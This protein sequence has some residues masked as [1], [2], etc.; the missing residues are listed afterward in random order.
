MHLCSQERLKSKIQSF[1]LECPGSHFSMPLCV[2]SSSGMFWGMPIE[3]F[4]ADII[5][6]NFLQILLHSQGNMKSLSYLIHRFI[7][8]WSVFYLMERLPSLSKKVFHPRKKS[9]A[10]KANC[11]SP[12]KALLGFQ[13]WCWKS[14]HWS[15]VYVVVQR[16]LIYQALLKAEVCHGREMSRYLNL[17]TSC[18]S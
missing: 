16:C 6:F 11:K 17:Y 5:F 10:A 1:K 12:L 3:W 13:L 4:A 8:K 14:N 9:N 7:Q 15:P 2:C 18:I